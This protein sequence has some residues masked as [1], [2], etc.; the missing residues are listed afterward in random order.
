MED[1][2]ST[3]NE[4]AYAIDWHVEKIHNVGRVRQPKRKHAV[5]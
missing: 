3:L 1:S 4:F 2:F 5:A